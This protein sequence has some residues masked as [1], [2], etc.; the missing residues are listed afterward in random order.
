MNELFYSKVVGYR[1][2][3]GIFFPW[4]FL[5]FLGQQILDDC[6]SFICDELH[7]LVTFLQF[8]K[9]ENTHGGVLLLIQLAAFLKITLFHVKLF[10]W[11][12]IAQSI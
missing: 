11:Y 1:R 6:L 12:Q 2:I 9:R 7:D 3:Q 4:K 10:K 5:K 8:K